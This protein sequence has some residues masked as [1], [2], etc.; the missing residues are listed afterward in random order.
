[1]A[2][3]ASGQSS[4]SPRR[5]C[6]IG[7]GVVGGATAYL[8]ARA[9]HEVTVIEAL[10]SPGLGTSYA[11]GGQL[12]Y[13]YVE[14]L[15][16]PATLRKLPS[17][18]SDPE[19][20]LR[21]RFTGEWSQLR[22][23]LQFVRAC[24]RAKVEATTRALL[25]LSFLSRDELDRARE[26]EVLS[27]RHAK[28]GKLVICDTPQSLQAAARQVEFQR[29]FGCQQTMLD[30]AA[31]LQREP[32]LAGYAAHVHG[33]V[34]TPD[35]AVGDAL[36]LSQHLVASAQASG[37]KVRYRTRVTGA[38]VHGDCIKALH[39]NHGPVHA[40]AFV[41]ANG[42]DAAALGQRL[43]VRLSIYPIK[44]YS[45]T[46]PLRRLEAAPQTSV[47]DLRRKT[48]Y[49]RL[50]SHLRI[51]G[52]AELVGHDLH[53][54]PARVRALVQCA[55][56]IFPGACD[57]QADPQPWV[58][59]RPATPSSLPLIGPARYANLLLNVGHGALGFTLAMGSAR[60]IERHLAGDPSPIGAP[61]AYRG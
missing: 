2:A 8:L 26:V 45:I 30:Q 61:F 39:T 37:A 6:V 57:T 13:S 47:T 34:W 50:G 58:G 41:L 43:G 18:L 42:A 29:Q 12:S 22:W 56:E 49:A 40:D 52:M 10:D 53:V 28:L 21:V 16:S 5:V 24:T 1:M 9:G 46:L 51:A 14:P 31:C 55:E 59:L 3:R 33:G 23:G 19:S 35:E 27:F 36:L 17:L 38:V 54:D 60:L 15:A 20:P 44:G 25:A 11:N 7:A 4:S 32:A 48:V